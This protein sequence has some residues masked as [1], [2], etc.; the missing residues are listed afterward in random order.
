MKILNL[1]SH[2]EFSNASCGFKDSINKL[3]D[4]LNYAYDNGHAG[5]G[6]TDHESVTGHIQAFDWWE[7]KITR[8]KKERK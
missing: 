5:I 6:L 1:H 2:S 8:S 3:E 4:L 7:N